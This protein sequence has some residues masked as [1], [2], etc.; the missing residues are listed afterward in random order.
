MNAMDKIVPDPPFR[1]IRPDLK[2]RLRHELTIRDDLS[3]KTKNNND[4]IESLM[5]LLDRENARY[6]NTNSIKEP[7]LPIDEFV[8]KALSTRPMSKDDLREAALG[9]GY[10]TDSDSPG[11]S[12]HAVT[13]NLGRSSKIKEIEPG[14]FALA[15]WPEPIKRRL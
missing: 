15:D 5:L 13:V 1:D 10:L 14:I 3:A 11:R 6:S 8:L 4:A 7:D 12:I 2:D 9:A